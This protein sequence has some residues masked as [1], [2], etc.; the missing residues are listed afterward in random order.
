MIGVAVA[1]ITASAI[2]AQ[3]L[4]VNVVTLTEEE[5]IVTCE[6]F[7]GNLW[8]FTDEDYDWIPGDMV[9]VIMDSKGTEIIYDDEFV[10]VKYDGYM[11]GWNR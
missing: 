2:Y 8:T 10:T 5:S 11:D 3:T 4:K 9:A 7:N 6:D 1:T